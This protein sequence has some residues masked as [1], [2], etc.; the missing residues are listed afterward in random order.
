MRHGLP[1][2]FATVVVTGA[3]LPAI[4]ANAFRT[5]S[6]IDGGKDCEHL[7][8]RG[9]R[10]DL[11]EPQSATDRFT[12]CVHLLNLGHRLRCYKLK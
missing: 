10:E 8:A 2:I 9:I 4:A 11:L 1:V 6:T 3:G 12:D 5:T 7:M